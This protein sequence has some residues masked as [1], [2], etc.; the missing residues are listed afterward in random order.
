MTEFNAGDKIRCINFDIDEGSEPWTKRHGC[1]I[2]NIYTVKEPI[3]D[4]W[5]DIIEDPKNENLHLETINFELVE[6]IDLSK[7]SNV[8]II[9]TLV[10]SWAKWMAMDKN[11]K[12]CVFSEKPREGNT[13]WLRGSRCSKAVSGNCDPKDIE[14]NWKETLHE[15]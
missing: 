2:G 4:K 8:K 14:V 6:Q 13:Q 9:N 15:I 3:D 12:W 11:G 1:I 5:I 10:P 7:N